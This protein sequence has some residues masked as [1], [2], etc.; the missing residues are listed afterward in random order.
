MYIEASVPPDRRSARNNL[1]SGI[2][3]V[4]SGLDLYLLPVQYFPLLPVQCFPLLPV[5]IS[6]SDLLVRIGDPDLPFA[7]A[8]PIPVSGPR[9]RSPFPAPVLYPVSDSVSFPVPFSVPF[10]VSD[11]VPFPGPLYISDS[12][13]RS[14]ILD[15]PP[16]R[17]PFRIPFPSHLPRGSASRCFS[18]CSRAALLYIDGSA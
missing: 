17:F 9:F 10:P 16:F 1:Y 5:R 12:V 8:I 15:R 4:S 14:S 11:S 7:A 6:D 13:P 18:L 2:P 3:H